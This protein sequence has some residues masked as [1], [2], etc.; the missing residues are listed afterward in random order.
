MWKVG[1]IKIERT[2]LQYFFPHPD[3]DIGEKVIFLVK[4]T[5]T[6]NFQRRNFSGLVPTESLR[7]QDSENV[8]GL[9]WFGFEGVG[10]QSE[11]IGQ[12]SDVS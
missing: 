5:V 1:G 3:T 6:K 9:V 11:V 12:K 8:F 2:P 4:R 7:T 10:A